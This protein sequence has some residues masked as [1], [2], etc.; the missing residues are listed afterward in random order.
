MSGDELKLLNLFCSKNDSNPLLR[1]PFLN[2]RYNEVWSTDRYSLIRFTSKKFNG[3]YLTGEL[4]LPE[5]KCACKKKITLEAIEEALNK[6]PQV[7]E[8]IIV[9]EA[10]GCIE[11]D[12]SGEVFWEYKDCNGHTYE[13]LYPCP[14]CNGTGEKSPKLCV[15]T[16][17]KTFGNHVLI[18]VGNTYLRASMLYKLKLSMLYLNATSAEL[19]FN[20]PKG[21]NEF[22]IGDVRIGLSSID[23]NEDGVMCYAQI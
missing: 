21:M 23:Y 11:C 14:V 2:T 8:E 7:D 17:R 4:P 15:K 18:K 3:D 12:D 16:G 20:P 5:Q 10:I 19:L 13:H 22:A 6:C 9:Q 1:T